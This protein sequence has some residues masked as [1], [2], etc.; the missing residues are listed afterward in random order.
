MT[1]IQKTMA[2]L[3]ALILMLSTAGALAQETA[4]DNNRL[5]AYLVTLADESKD[6]WQ[7]AIYR[8]GA[9]NLSMEGDTLSFYLRG[10]AP[11]VKSLPKFAEDPEG[12]LTGFFGN[13]GEYGLAA[14]LAFKEGEPTKNSVTKLK[15]TV[16]SAAAKAKEAFGQQTV[17]TALLDLLFPV[18]YKDAA[19]Y[20]NSTVSPAFEQWVSRM[21]VEQHKAQAFSALLYA[22]TGRQLNLKKGPH[23]LEFSVKSTAPA[24]LLGQGEK[25]VMADLSK[26]AKANAMES[27]RLQTLFG[28]GILQAAG[29][30]RKKAADKQVF[31]ADIDQLALGSTGEG[32]DSFL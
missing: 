17:K 20:K 28:Q 25:A 23:A 16:K 6:P 24:D 21:G 5:N 11:N 22:Q 18:P 14:S 27:D 32:Y 26:V 29:P 12:W 10:F 2:L 30:L 15:S 8:A 7:Q 31:T 4:W 13:V 19:A 1:R 3:L 9:E